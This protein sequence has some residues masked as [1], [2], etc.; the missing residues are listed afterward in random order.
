MLL[1]VER[2]GEAVSTTELVRAMDSVRDAERE[3]DSARDSVRVAVLEEKREPLSVRVAEAA[4]E[5]LCV[6]SNH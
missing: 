5:D 1:V 2:V 4:L 3:K 6:V